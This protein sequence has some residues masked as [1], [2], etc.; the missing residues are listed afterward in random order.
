LK[1]TFGLFV[2][3]REGR[4]GVLVVNI[5]KQHLAILDILDKK[6]GVLEVLLQ[7]VLFT[8]LRL[9]RLDIG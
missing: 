2:R 7:L 1:G 9:Q 5:R 3:L 8:Q 6:F 4:L